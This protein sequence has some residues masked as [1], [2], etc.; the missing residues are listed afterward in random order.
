MST[1]ESRGYSTEFGIAHELY[2]PLFRGR[3]IRQAW[4]NSERCRSILE[5]AAGGSHQESVAGR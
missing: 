3:Q 1:L 4:K 5:K 2:L